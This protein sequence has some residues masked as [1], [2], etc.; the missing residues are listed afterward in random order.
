MKRSEAKEVNFCTM[1]LP[2]NRMH[3][4][5]VPIVVQ[6]VKNPTSIHE[7][8]GLIPGLDQWVKGASIA[9]SCGV[10]C[11]RGSDLSL[12]WLWCRLAAQL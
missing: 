3:I 12:L 6:W 8:A 11:R 10:G 9:V 1:S 5:G 4:S 2:V 7:A